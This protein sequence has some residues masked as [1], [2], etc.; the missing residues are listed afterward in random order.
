MSRGSLI[1]VTF[2]SGDKGKAVAS[3]VDV[4]A[5]PGSA[6]VFAGNLS[7][8]DMHKGLL[9]LTDP[10]DDKGYEVPLILRASLQFPAFTMGIPLGCPRSLTV[11]AM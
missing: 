3:K 7:S 10:L 2:N 4:L 6:F 1:S 11:L 9:D 5:T 8:L